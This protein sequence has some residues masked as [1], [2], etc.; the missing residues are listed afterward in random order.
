VIDR[1]MTVKDVAVIY[2]VSRA[3]VYGWIKN[4]DLVGIR[5]PGGDHRFRRE[6]LD[7]FEQKCRERRS[8]APT[9]DSERAAE[10]GASLGRTR[11]PVAL[12]AFQR[13]RMSGSFV[14]TRLLS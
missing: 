4:G 1:A 11:S 2:G 3:T 14:R 13:G 12:D 8:P 5:L 6:H 10:S 7:A 9:T